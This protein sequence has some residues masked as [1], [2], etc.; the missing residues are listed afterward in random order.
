MAGGIKSNKAPSSLD[1]NKKPLLGHHRA[2]SFGGPGES[3]NSLNRWS[4]STTSSKSSVTHQRSSSLARRLS[5]SFGSLGNQRPQFGNAQKSDNR[6][7]RLANEMTIVSPAKASSSRQHSRDMYSQNTQPTNN[8]N[9]AVTPLT[10]DSQ[11]AGNNDY[12]GQAWNNTSPSRN[13]EER[14]PTS[15]YSP[16]RTR[17]Q[18]R[19]GA[20][21]SF[22]NFSPAVGSSDSRRPRSPDLRAQA[23]TDRPREARHIATNSEER[24]GTENPSIAEQGSNAGTRRRRAPSQK[25]MLSRALQKA[26]HAVVLDH[27][28]NFEGAIRAYNEACELLEQ[29]M[30]RSSGGED[31]RKLEAIVSIME[32]LRSRTN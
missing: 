8:P 5:G 25:A 22:R 27:N 10:M 11:R 30:V 2:S 14:S 32:L 6:P 13:Y 16:E 23:Q 18:I 20:N 15:P 1:S 26:N 7:H 3:L 28:S 4:Q 21:N 29:V 17:S 31:R 9:P 24:A 12:F 19:P